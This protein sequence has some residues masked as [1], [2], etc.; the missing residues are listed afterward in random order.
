MLRRNGKSLSESHPRV[1]EV[2]QKRLA[3]LTSRHFPDVRDRYWAFEELGFNKSFAANK[4]TRHKFM[5]KAGYHLVDGIWK[6]D[7]LKL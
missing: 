3:I 4:S 2:F 1:V 5:E 7:L 6:G